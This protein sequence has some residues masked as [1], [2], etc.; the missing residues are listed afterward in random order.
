MEKFLYVTYAEIYKVLIDEVDK[1][2]KEYSRTNL[3]RELQSI[4]FEFLE[5]IRQDHLKA[6]TECFNVECQ[7]PFTMATT[8]FQRSQKEALALLTNLRRGWRVQM[9][10]EEMQSRVEANGGRVLPASKVTD[11][12]LGPDEFG[13]EIEIM[14][15]SAV[16]YWSLHMSPEC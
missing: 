10:V 2:F 14:S 3:Y 1:V 15:V 11:T 5:S 8:S 16:Q 9:Y 4:I 7:K 13:K 6:A 12:E